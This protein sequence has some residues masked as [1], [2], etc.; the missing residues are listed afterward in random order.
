MT[1]VMANP[2]KHNTEYVNEKN[3]TFTHDDKYLK[4]LH[5]TF[6][7][8]SI[9]FFGVIMSVICMMIAIIFIM[10]TTLYTF[11]EDKLTSKKV[12]IP[13]NLPVVVVG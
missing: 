8:T 5:N 7:T 1:N 13:K 2:N 12:D 10:M 6:G 9:P 3:Q 4:Y 11:D